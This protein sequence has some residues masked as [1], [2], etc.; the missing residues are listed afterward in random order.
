[1]CYLEDLYVDP[2]RRCAGVGKPLIDWLLAEMKTQ[3]WSRLYW[4][5]RVNNY[6]ARAMY[7]KYTPQSGFVRYVIS[8][9][10]I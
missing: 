3:H 6:R 1:M 4:N 9:P 5:T 10:A 8:S 2:D 7:D